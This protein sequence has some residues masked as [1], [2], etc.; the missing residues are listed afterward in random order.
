MDGGDVHCLCGGTPQRDTVLLSATGLGWTHPPPE[1]MYAARV[2]DVNE[3]RYRGIE[4]FLADHAGTV[5]I[6][7][8]ITTRPTSFGPAVYVGSKRIAI[9][10][11]V[12]AEGDNAEKLE[13]SLQTLYAAA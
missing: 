3:R 4:A 9:V 7:R 10:A 2:G 1:H 11:F 6:G 13:E 8:R 5:R 12:S